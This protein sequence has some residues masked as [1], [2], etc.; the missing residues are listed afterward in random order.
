MEVVSRT[1]S[2][3]DEHATSQ[4]I[5]NIQL[6]RMGQDYPSVLCIQVVSS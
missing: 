6:R 1:T 4:Q 3:L 5:A 2:S